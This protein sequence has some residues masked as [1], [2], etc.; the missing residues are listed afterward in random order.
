MAKE[1]PRSVRTNEEQGPSGLILYEV[2]GPWQ[3]APQFR[4]SNGWL[5]PVLPVN[6]FDPHKR[7]WT[8]TVL[9]PLQVQ[10]TEGAPLGTEW[11]VGDS[12]QL[13]FFVN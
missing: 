7:E 10:R 3:L 9:T 11:A 6:V 12:L 13:I 5:L 4:L 2:V 8:E 1:Y